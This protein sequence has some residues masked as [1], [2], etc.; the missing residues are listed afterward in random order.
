[1]TNFRIAL[2]K[3]ASRVMEFIGEHWRHGHIMSEDS[4]LFLYE[5]EEGPCLNFGLA[6]NENDEL[7]GIFGFMKYNRCE[8]TDL[9]GSFWAVT[10]QDRHPMLGIKLR[11][12]VMENIPHRFFGAPGAAPK[13][14]PI[15]NVLGMQWCRMSQCFVLN[16]RLDT[17]Q[18]VRIPESTKLKYPLSVVPDD[19]EIAGLDTPEQLE[20]FP[21]DTYKEVRPFKDE[22]YVKRRFFEH[23]YYRY[24][25]YMITQRGHPRGL[26]VTREVEH[27]HARAL[28]VV[29]FYGKSDSIPWLATWLR[30]EVISEVYEYA[31]FLCH[32]VSPDI[33]S[34]AGFNFLDANQQ[35]LIIPHYF[36]PF[37]QRNV[38]IYCVGDPVPYGE[39]RMFKADGDQDRPNMRPESLS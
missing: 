11:Q 8:V 21:F 13:T 17:Y 6:T 33:L 1:M 24:H 19:V 10:E 37:E 29:D 25:C 26:F 30:Q 9:A 39:F 15:Y 3:D 18:L 12:F 16:D 34:K 20:Q 35:E 7:I 32:G 27:N 31:D 5:F 4:E 22:W 36:E 14:E 23:P 38:A 28:R 2:P